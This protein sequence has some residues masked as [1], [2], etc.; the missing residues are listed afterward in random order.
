MSSPTM[1]RPFLR[2]V[3]A[4]KDNDALL[5]D[6]AI[7][8]RARAAMWRLVEAQRL[9]LP[10]IRRGLAHPN[11]VVRV[12]CCEVLDHYL[13]VTPGPIS[14]SRSTM[15]IRG[16]V[17]WRAMPCRVAAAR[18][19][20]RTC[21]RPSRAVS[22]GWSQARTLRHDSNNPRRGASPSHQPCVSAVRS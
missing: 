11:P 2:D 13:G 15:T 9:A 22:H 16:F 10:A 5:E 3:M 18:R 4:A 12:G 19:V 14:S 7:P 21:K 8:H 6:L 20:L 17:G 1:P